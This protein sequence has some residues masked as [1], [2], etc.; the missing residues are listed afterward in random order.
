MPVT[1]GMADFFFFKS[2]QP[3]PCA[4][5]VVELVAE[6]IPKKF[7]LD[8]RRDIQ[9]LSPMHRG[10]AGVASLNAMLQ[11]A[12]NPQ[13]EGHV[14]KTFGSN[15]FRLGD[16]VMQMRNNYDLDVYNGDIG[17]VTAIDMVEQLLTVRY[18]A[19]RDIAY[20]FALLDELTHAYAISIH[21]SQGAEYPC[22]VIPLL[23]QHYNLLQRNL[24]YTGV[25]RAK[26]LV[27]LAG[28]RRALARAVANNEVSQ[29]YTGLARRMKK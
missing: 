8:P 11:Q 20:D 22:V 25:T 7:G 6:R 10:E 17:E 12:L 16:R 29:R 19:E 27:V 23:M 21:K 1:E 3:Q 14:E 9:V 26:K 2:P 13:R 5:M 18:D 24:I 4:E 28:D 15:T